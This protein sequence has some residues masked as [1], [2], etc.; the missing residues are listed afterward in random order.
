[1]FRSRGFFWVLAVAV[2]TPVSD[3]HHCMLRWKAPF[4]LKLA[5]NDSCGISSFGCKNDMVVEQNKLSGAFR[6]LS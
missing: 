3:N 4:S 5:P 2:F 1:M 6:L